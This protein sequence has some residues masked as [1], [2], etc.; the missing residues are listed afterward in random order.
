M[1]Y[2]LMCIHRF[3]HSILFY[4]INFWFTVVWIKVYI[5][6]TKHS[7]ATRVKEHERNCHQWSNWSP[8]KSAIAEHFIKTGH[9]MRSEC[10][11]LPSSAVQYHQR[12]QMETSEIYKNQDNINRKKAIALYGY[13]YPLLRRTSITKQIWQKKGLIIGEVFILIC[14]FKNSSSSEVT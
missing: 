5:A 2:I 6:S 14:L 9:K 10:T 4:Y 1:F 13:W 3:I 11:N 12:R 8:E 7:V